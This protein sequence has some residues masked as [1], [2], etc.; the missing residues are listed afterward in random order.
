MTNCKV[1]TYVPA[2]PV[3][4]VF[5]YNEGKTDI[6][7][8]KAAGILPYS[9]DSKGRLHIYAIRE[10][11]TRNSKSLSGKMEE[12]YSFPGGKIKKYET[13]RS[14]AMRECKEESGLDVMLPMSTRVLHFANSRYL[15]FPYHVQ[16]P[17]E[18]KGAEFPTYK[19]DPL[20][21]NKSDFHLYSWDMLQT[22]LSLGVLRSTGLRTTMGL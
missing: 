16:I 13:I 18:L 12:L 10:P 1:A 5:T 15:L 8:A 9:I 21:C 20:K 11:R 14:A 4:E 19:L 22:A 7:K 3:V 2:M 6:P 17:I